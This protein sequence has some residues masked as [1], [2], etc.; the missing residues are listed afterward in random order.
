MP[1]LPYI[2]NAVS[3]YKNVDT[4]YGKKNIC[5]LRGSYTV[6]EKMLTVLETGGTTYITSTVV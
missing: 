4:V 1:L 3:H 5:L 2:K 6:W